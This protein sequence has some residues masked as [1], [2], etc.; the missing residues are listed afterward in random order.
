MVDLNSLG[1]S[2]PI[3]KG[4]TVETFVLEGM[5]AKPGATGAFTSLLN[6]IVT[7]VKIISSRVRAAGLADV[8]GWT[9]HT[10]VQ[11]EQVQKL[12][13][14]ANDVL[15]GVLERR[16]HCGVI[17][18]EEM[19]DPLIVSPE[20]R[21]RYIVLFDPLDGSSNIDVN[22]SIGTIFGILRRKNEPEVASAAEQLL[23]PGRELVAAGYAL[24]GSSTMLVL[25]TGIESGVQGFTLDPA[26]GDFFL[27]HAN[28]RCPE[29]GSI[30][31]VNEGNFELWP[32]PIRRWNSH[33]KSTD[34]QGGPM[35]QRYVGSL[36]A[37]AHRTL[38]KGGIFVYPE[39]KK[40]PCGKLR[41][42]YEAN[43]MAMI[44]E[45]AGGVATDG[46]R[47][48]LDIEPK[49][50]HERVPLVL[51][52]KKNVALFETFMNQG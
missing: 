2:D 12:D 31:S 34:V 11:G 19:E 10:N 18:S 40:N 16:G 15:I 52:S 37:D 32:E 38:L 22:I 51:G 3:H 33:V 44:F 25:T 47:R 6:Q 26:V 21:A 28:I 4:I 9:G 39:D 29:Q 20:L 7:S 30:Y 27:S 50:I 36:V 46:T 45:A 1:A 42:L 5:K 14:Y 17:A 43:P 35:G 41:L 24:Y 23:R 48:V 49:A 13:E 8:L